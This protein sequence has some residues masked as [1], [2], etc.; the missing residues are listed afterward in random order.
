MAAN[1]SVIVGPSD[2]HLE[3]FTG[4]TGESGVTFLGNFLTLSSLWSDE[5]K[6]LSFEKYLVGPALNWCRL[7]KRKSIRMGDISNWQTFSTDFLSEFGTS[8]LSRVWN[9]KQA[10]DESGISLFYH[11]CL[12]N[13][14]HKLDLGDK[15][16]IAWVQG[17]FNQKYTEK[18]S[19][20]QFTSI[21][22]FKLAIQS[23]DAKFSKKKLTQK[24]G[25]CSKIG[26]TARKCFLR[27]RLNKIRRTDDS[28][29]VHHSSLTVIR[30][31]SASTQFN[32]SEAN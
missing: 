19:H 29:V 31:S 12:Q 10:N 7:Y 24:C 32:V 2:N 11:L 25:F 28:V 1:V 20:V 22:E 13:E 4:E 8:E 23:A 17:K 9:K 6:V 21:E 15:Q 27:R 16:M 18:L 5:V 26:H 30:H 14:E 3:K